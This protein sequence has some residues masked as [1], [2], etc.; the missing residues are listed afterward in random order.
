MAQEAKRGCGYRKV[1][2][3]YLIG[4]QLSAPC[5]RLPYKLEVCPVCG[6]G[7]KPSRG[8]TQINPLHLFGYHLD[9]HDEYRP[10]I[11]CDPKDEVAYMMNVGEKFYRTPEIF[12]EEARAMGVSKRIPFVP[13]EL[14][15]GKTVIYLCH[16]KAFEVYDYDKNEVLAQIPKVIGTALERELNVFGPSTLNVCENVPQVEQID[17]LQAQGAL[18]TA[19]KKKKVYGI[20]AAFIPQRVEKL[21]WEH[22]ATID[23]LEKLEKHG[24]TPVIIKNGDIDHI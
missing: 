13:K 23:E 20:F 15:L 9:C 11:V 7:V 14:K 1:G 21:L 12:M 24:I 6:A 10:C 17:F 5:D 22:Q 4:G 16:P 18:F 19:E 8:F 3:Y 2:G